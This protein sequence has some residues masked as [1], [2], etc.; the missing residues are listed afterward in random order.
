MADGPQY[1]VQLKRRREGRTD[2]EKR[3]EM[4][5][6]GDVRAVIRTSNNHTRVQLVQYSEPGDATV[7]S[8]VSADLAA[9]GWDGHTGNLPAAYLTGFL[10]GHR[11]QSG[12]V[13]VERAIAD[14][15]AIERADG[16]RHYA[17]VKGLQDAGLDVPA[18]ADVFPP[19]DRLRGAHLEEGDGATD[20]F[21]DV[22]G[23]I[24]TEYGDS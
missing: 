21:E 12:D 17:A 9:F 22:R 7:T 13:T 14:L 4:L 2:Y 5:K 10:A 1:E 11:A 6:S 23:S 15:G 16:G 20:T 24:E 19:E 18:D 3:L 8:A